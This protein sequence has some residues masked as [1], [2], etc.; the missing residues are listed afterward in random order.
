MSSVK[1]IYAERRGVGSSL[2]DTWII[3]L[4][5]RIRR[6]IPPGNLEKHKGL[7]PEIITFGIVTRFSPFLRF[8]GWDS[9]RNLPGKVWTQFSM[10]DCDSNLLCVLISFRA[11]S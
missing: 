5:R 3:G 2:L 6:P 10:R 8:V 7:G 11:S 9:A 4:S 1:C